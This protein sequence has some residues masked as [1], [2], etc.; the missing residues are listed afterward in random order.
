[1][2]PAD[3]S[4]DDGNN[5]SSQVSLA[6]CWCLPH[7]HSHLHPRRNAATQQAL[8]EPVTDHRS[9]TPQDL[10]T[11]HTKRKRLFTAGNWLIGEINALGSCDWPD[12]VMGSKHCMWCFSPAVTCHCPV[13]A[14]V[15]F[16]TRE[17]GQHREELF[18][19]GFSTQRHTALGF[20]S[21]IYG[22]TGLW[23][24]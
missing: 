5:S 22:L 10:N 12:Q 8:K 6:L 18:T 16:Y 1:M 3:D 19:S 4:D 7:T 11:K 15:A 23:A 20:T 2:N 13:W 24:H 17:T 9:E 14:L 21:I